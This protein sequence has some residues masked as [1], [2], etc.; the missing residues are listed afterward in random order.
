[1]GRE[2]GIRAVTLVL[3]GGAE[4]GLAPVRPWSP[5]YLRMVPIARAVA[6]ATAR[7]GVEVRLLRNRV[8]GWNS[9]QLHPVSDARHALE[10][11]HAERPGVPVFLV[12]HSMGGR[13]A[14]RVADDPAV[15]SVCALA[16]WTPAG[17]PVEPVRGRDVVLAHGTLDRIT[18]PAE[19]FAYAR[20]AQAVAA[21]LLRFELM[22]ESHA[23]LLRAPAWHRLVRRFVL[24]ALGVTPLPEWDKVP[25]QR[26]RLPA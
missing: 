25:E 8:R 24:D 2:S 22:S 15:T 18:E 23:M 19:S 20:R 1:M 21:R 26:L 7:Y 11:I 4:T 3:H 16:P 13:V 9:P 14:L 6:T 10:R 17:E 12:G 5:A